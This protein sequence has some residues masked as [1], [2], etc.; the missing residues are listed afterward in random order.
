MGP[1]GI[2]EMM[3]IFVIALLLFGPKK[4]PELGRILGKAFS[5]FRR[6]KNEIKNTFDM[7]MRELERETRME[8]L[9]S[10]QGKLE[11]PAWNPPAPTPAAYNPPSYTYSYPYDESSPYGST[12][13]P[14]EEPVAPPPPLTPPTAGTVAR[15]GGIASV[16]QQ[17]VRPA[18]GTSD[19]HSRS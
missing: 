17:P 16:A 6:A 3:A 8:E 19:N 14:R 15:S 12:S 7:H 13:S 18:D 4:L 2:P 10:N 9:K 5:E 1:I 11:A